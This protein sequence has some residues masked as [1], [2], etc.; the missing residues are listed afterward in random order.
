MLAHELGH[1]LGGNAEGVEA[2]EFEDGYHEAGNPQNLISNFAEQPEGL[3]GFE[4]R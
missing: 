2:P 4:L 3:V 1:Y